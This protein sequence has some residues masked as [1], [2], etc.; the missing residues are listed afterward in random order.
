MMSDE[1]K[2]CLSL[3]RKFELVGLLLQLNHGHE[4]RAEILNVTPLV[5]L[6]LD[7]GKFAAMDPLR[8]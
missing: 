2:Y 3:E 7:S 5:L 1:L 6:D 8:C 4:N